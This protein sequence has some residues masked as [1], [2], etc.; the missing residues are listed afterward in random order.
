MADHCR[1]PKCGRKA[2]SL[3]DLYCENCKAAMLRKM[4][5]EGYFLAPTEPIRETKTQWEKA[6][7]ES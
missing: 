3:K 2:A 6:V 4:K 1:N 5:R 7:D